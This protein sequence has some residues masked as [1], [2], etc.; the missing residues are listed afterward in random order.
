MKQPSLSI[1]AFSINLLHYLKIAKVRDESKRLTSFSTTE[2]KMY[3]PRYR[4]NK[5]QKCIK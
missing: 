1:I 2:I 3:I 4:S 5:L